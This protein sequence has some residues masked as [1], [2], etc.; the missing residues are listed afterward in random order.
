MTHQGPVDKQYKLIKYVIEACI[1][2]EWVNIHLPVRQFATCEFHNTHILSEQLCTDSVVVNKTEFLL[3]ESQHIIHNIKCSNKEKQNGVSKITK[4]ISFY[5]GCVNFIS[6]QNILKN[7]KSDD[8]LQISFR[9]FDKHNL[10]VIE[11]N[12]TLF[13]LPMYDEKDCPPK[14]VTTTNVNQI[15]YK[16]SFWI[17]NW[18]F[19]KMIKCVAKDSDIVIETKQNEIIIKSMNENKNYYN[20]ESRTKQYQS[21]PIVLREGSSIF[22]SNVMLNLLSVIENGNNLRIFCGD[23][24]P[25]KI[26]FNIRKGISTQYIISNKIKC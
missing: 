12:E 7:F 19:A 9:K 5:K 10:F 26:T 23:N 16:N 6:L 14:L 13:T 22:S 2:N 15:E 4:D 17:D 20:S 3:E 11:H 24:T 21:S 25:M 8:K 18:L 1:L